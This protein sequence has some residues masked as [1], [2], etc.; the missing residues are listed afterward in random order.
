MLSGIPDMTREGDDEMPR[1]EGWP[2]RPVGLTGARVES[3]GGEPGT[4]EVIEANRKAKGNTSKDLRD[5]PLR[6]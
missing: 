1:I 5:V 4:V 6:R 2:Q 3:Y